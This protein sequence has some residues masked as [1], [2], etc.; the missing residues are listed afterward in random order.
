MLE[1]GALVEK[2]NSGFRA[3]E[4]SK[5]KMPFCP[6]STLSSPPQARTFLSAER[7]QWCGSLPTFPGGGTGTVR[8][9]FP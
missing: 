6:E 4:T 2:R 1:L 9:T 7:W 3:L 5:K 8:S